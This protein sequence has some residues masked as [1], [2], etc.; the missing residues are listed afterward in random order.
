MPMGK[1]AKAKPGE[2]SRVAGRLLK[3]TLKPIDRFN[4]DINYAP[5][6]P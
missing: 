4:R 5:V 3:A 2:E 1:S 6:V